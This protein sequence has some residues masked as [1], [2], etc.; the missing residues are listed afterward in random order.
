MAK[1]KPVEVWI[2]LLAVAVFITGLSFYM[3]NHPGQSPEGY[4]STLGGEKVER[5]ADWPKIR[6]AN[7]EELGLYRGKQIGFSI[8]LPLKVSLGT[9]ESTL[10]LSVYEDPKNDMVHITLPEDRLFFS[11]AVVAINAQ[12]VAEAANAWHVYFADAHNEKDL[13]RFIRNHYGPVCNVVSSI[14]EA[15]GVYNIRIDDEGVDSPNCAASGPYFIKYD[16][17]M[18]RAAT[19]MVGNGGSFTYQ[20]GDVT[21]DYWYPMASSLRFFQLGKPELE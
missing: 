1:A 12:N 3:M 19:W 20:D 9:P 14:R 13:L 15:S 16:A 18:E 8:R 11:D 17:A 10:Q 7:P 4:T 5:P 21:V 6:D 2:Q